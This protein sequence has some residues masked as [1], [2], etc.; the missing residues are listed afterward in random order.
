MTSSNPNDESPSQRQYD[1][2]DRTF[3]FAKDVIAFVDRIPRTIAN[4]EIAK[5]L[6]KASGSVGANYIE[7]NE[8]LGRKDFLMKI[9]ISRKESKES[10]YW[11]R[12]V[13]CEQDTEVTQ[14]KLVQE[15]TELMKIFGAILRNSSTGS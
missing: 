12:L 6:V 9:R 8:S 10:R 15:S 13:S 4:V 5:Q 1:L 14:A 2:E 7:A 11:L 3:R